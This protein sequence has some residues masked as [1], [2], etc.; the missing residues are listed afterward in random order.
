MNNTIV[1]QLDHR[2]V[3]LAIQ[4]SLKPGAY[5]PD[6]NQDQRLTKSEVFDSALSYRKLRGF[7]HHRATSSFALR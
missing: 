3:K 5:R 1:V 6:R 2:S 4:P 7:Q